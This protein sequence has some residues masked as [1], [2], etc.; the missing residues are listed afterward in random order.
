MFSLSPFQT[1]ILI[2]PEHFDK[3]NIQQIGKLL[4]ICSSRHIRPKRH[5]DISL[6]QRSNG[7]KSKGHFNFQYFLF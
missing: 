5:Y 2:N 1:E 7:S 6:L 4:A 3:I